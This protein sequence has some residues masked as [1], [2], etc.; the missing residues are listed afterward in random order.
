MVYIS[1]LSALPYEFSLES[2]PT[3]FEIVWQFLLFLIVEDTLFYWGHR[4]LHHPKLY[5]I[6]KHHHEY[7]Q[8]IGF[9][10]QYVHP[11]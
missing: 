11:L 7:H 10:S 8:T 1:L 2:W 6:H 9:A 5:W 3:T 4:M